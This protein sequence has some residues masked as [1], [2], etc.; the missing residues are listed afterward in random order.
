MRVL[1]AAMLLMLTAGSNVFA[2]GRVNKSTPNPGPI[3]TSVQSMRWLPD[4][5]RTSRGVSGSFGQPGLDPNRGMSR[6]QVSILLGMLG[7]ALGGFVVADSVCHAEHRPGGEECGLA[8]RFYGLPIGA[9][10]GGITVAWL[11]K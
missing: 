8:G 6:R 2:G 5:T 1:V 9:A 10:A 7:G 11:T 3:Q 4:V